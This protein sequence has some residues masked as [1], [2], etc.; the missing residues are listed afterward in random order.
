MT[1]KVHEE[2]SK[3]TTIDIDIMWMPDYYIYIY[4]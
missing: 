4:I 3:M 1:L 2:F